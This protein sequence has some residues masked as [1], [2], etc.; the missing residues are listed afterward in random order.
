M[1]ALTADLQAVQEQVLQAVH[2]QV[3]QAVQAQATMQAKVAALTAELQA[4]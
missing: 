1:A 2:G 4:V 3:L